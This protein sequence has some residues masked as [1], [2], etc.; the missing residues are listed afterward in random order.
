MTLECIQDSISSFTSR[1][2][3]TF[4]IKPVLEEYLFT[5]K[6]FYKIQLVSYYKGNNAAL[7]WRKI[8][9]LATIAMLP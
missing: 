3:V 6:Y 5:K 7:F 2:K 8:I 1:E 9:V 4:Q